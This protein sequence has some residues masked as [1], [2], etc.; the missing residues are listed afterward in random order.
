MLSSI[1][2]KNFLSYENVRVDFEGAESISLVGENGSGKSS[3]LEALPFADY[4]IGRYQYPA[5]YTR[6]NAG[7]SFEVEV[8]RKDTPG[9]GDVL[10]VRRGLKDGKGFARL[11]L[12]DELL[13][14]GKDVAP[15]VLRLTGLDADSFMLTSFFGLGD[16]DKSDPLLKVIPSKC[17]ETLQKIANVYIYTKFYKRV[18]DDLKSVKSV[19]ALLENSVEIM[20]KVVEDVP[21]LKKSLERVKGQE[22]ALVIKLGDLRTKRND[23]MIKEEKYQAVIRERDTMQERRKQLRSVVDK[24]GKQ[25]RSLQS[26]IKSSKDSLDEMIEKRESLQDKL[27]QSNINEL[28]EECNVLYSEISGKVTVRELKDVAVSSDD[29]STS[30]CPLC[31]SPI[32]EETIKSWHKDIARLDKELTKLKENVANKNENV[33]SLRKSD[34]RLAVLKRDVTNLI[35]LIKDVQ[36]K[37]KDLK[38]RRT[39]DE[40]ALNKADS[41]YTGLCKKLNSSGYSKVSTDLQEINDR[42]ETHQR[43]SG[44]VKQ[45]ISTLQ[46][47]IAENIKRNKELKSSKQELSQSKKTARALSILVDAWS[48]YGIPLNLLKDLTVAIEEKATE[49][50]QEFDSGAILIQNVEGN[51]PGLRFVLSDRKGTRSFSGLSLGEKVMFFIAVRVAVSQ[52]ITAAKDIKIDYLVLDEGMGNLSP[53]NRDN[54]VRLINRILR[55]IFPQVIMVSHT[56]MRSIFSR[57]IQVEVEGDTSMATVL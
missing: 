32:T 6:L 41:R 7:D 23:L 36:R 54:L 9:S 12:N 25:L 50:Y 42:V 33:K 57:T 26:D 46:D 1:S 14:K 52:I 27:K 5:E 51:K 48:R 44:A 22:D 18:V 53:D 31:E 20:E 34:K 55:K 49:I 45:E 28:S 40:D 16:N 29:L 35:D 3:L 38:M 19:M 21:S 39:T 30:A 37:F 4:G 13:A 15:N 56:E 47:S 11:W 10:R 17:L 43:K 24:A 2:L 8:I